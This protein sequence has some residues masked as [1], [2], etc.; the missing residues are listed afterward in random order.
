MDLVSRGASVSCTADPHTILQI[1]ELFS[2]VIALHS[3][4]ETLK[5]LSLSLLPRML[6]G[7]PTAMVAIGFSIGAFIV[8]WNKKTWDLLEEVGVWW[9]EP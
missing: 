8:D 2:P 1:G 4:D 9:C 5:P 6:Y 3:H 7:D